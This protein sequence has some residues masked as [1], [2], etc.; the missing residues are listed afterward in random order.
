MNIKQELNNIGLG[1]KNAVVI[2]SGILNALN[3]RE[4]KDI[5]VVVD[6]ETYNRLS[7]SNKFEK[8]EKHNR[9]I[10]EDELFEIG[11]SWAVLGRD[12]DFDDLSKHSIIID[13]V[14]YN[15]IEFLLELKR[16]W[17]SDGAG[18]PKDIQDIELIEK[19][20]SKNIIYNK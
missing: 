11:T 17:V 19:Y 10:L 12:W 18:R 2:G 9:E 14:R 13:E 3:I 4:S 6:I 7:E 1:A 20:L 15:T 5:D 16:S 8:V